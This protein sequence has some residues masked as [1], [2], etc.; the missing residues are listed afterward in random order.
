M[1]IRWRSRLCGCPLDA[2]CA[3][4]RG[5]SDRAHDSYDD[6]ELELVLNWL[7][8]LR[9]SSKRVASE[10]RG[11]AARRPELRRRGD[12]RNGAGRVEI[13]LRLQGQS[14][15]IRIPRTKLRC[16]G[17]MKAANRCDARWLGGT[18]E[19]GRV[20]LLFFRLDLGRGGCWRARRC[21]RLAGSGC[22]CARRR[23]PSLSRG[24]P[25]RPWRWTCA[26]SLGGRLARCF[27]IKVGEHLHF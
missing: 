16:A 25:T 4:Y 10:E 15:T 23:L 6:F 14:P 22:C 26:G 24:R 12:A 9:L 27:R 8:S 17:R 5:L 19:E 1:D 7:S 13:L 21:G 20:G 3:A 11:A 18:L 2:P